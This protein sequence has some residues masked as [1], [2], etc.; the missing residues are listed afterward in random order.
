MKSPDELKKK[1]LETIEKRL[2]NQIINA[3]IDDIDYIVVETSEVPS[4]IL[5]NVLEKYK[6]EN[7]I[8]TVD[9]Y[10]ISWD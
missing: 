7:D 1:I 3:M 8:K 6:V 2:E 10:R 5:G 9:R 4:S